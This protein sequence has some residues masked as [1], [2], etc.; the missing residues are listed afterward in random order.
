MIF[1][2]FS[3]IVRM[4]FWRTPWTNLWRLGSLKCS[5]RHFEKPMLLF[6][7][8]K[9]K[10]IIAIV[11]TGMTPPNTFEEAVTSVKSLTD[12]TNDDKLKLYALF[13]C[14][15]V[16]LAPNTTQ[17]SRFN[18]V[19]RAKWDS[20]KEMGE[21]LSTGEEAKREY[22][23]FVSGK[24]GGGVL[25]GNRR[26]STCGKTGTVTVIRCGFKSLPGSTLKI[27]KLSI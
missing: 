13:K 5:E 2:T 23:E 10:K 4:K 7:S 25:G 24:M 3:K 1:G 26:S 27:K 9:K 19:A 21:R 14:A 12:L 6:S 17:P 11:G 18:A 16:S 15:T 22:L 20:W 8:S